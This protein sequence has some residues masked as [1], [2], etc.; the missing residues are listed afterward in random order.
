[1]GSIAT[2]TPKG[3][4]QVRLQLDPFF[5]ISL[6][7]LSSIEAGHGVR[8]SQPVVEVA[9]DADPLEVLEAQYSTDSVLAAVTHA[10][11]E[12]DG[13]AQRVIAHVSPE[14]NGLDVVLDVAELVSLAGWLN[15][16]FIALSHDD[17]GAEAVGSA[18]G[19]LFPDEAWEQLLGS[20]E[21]TEA[22]PRAEVPTDPLEL[23]QGIAQVLSVD[24]LTAHYDLT[25]TGQ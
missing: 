19:N 2:I 9:P 24:L 6:V 1:M 7:V 10:H 18:G 13:V 20:P 11:S 15:R 25:V 22:A 21:S 5:A 14:S 12:Q 3:T 16:I 4:D 17:A 8:G 23:L